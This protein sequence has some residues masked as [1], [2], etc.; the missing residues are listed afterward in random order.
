MITSD[1]L[2]KKIQQILD[3]HKAIDI[4]LLDVSSLTAI[5]D[6]MVI[7]SGTSRRH[8][9]ALKNHVVTD[10]KSED[11]RAIGIE[12]EDLG[13]WV[14]I[15]YGNVLVHIMQEKTR[16]FYALEKLWEVSTKMLA[17]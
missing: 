7:C 12:G 17:S 16:E 9:N 3:E 8:V 10:L 14:L 2:A 15:D 4:N 5:T 13:E 11:I 6:Y 1:I